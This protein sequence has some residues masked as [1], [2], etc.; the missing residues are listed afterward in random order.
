M[1]YYSITSSF[2]QGSRAGSAR[3]KNEL[4]EEARLGSFEAHEPL[5]AEPS[6]TELEPAR[7]PR[8][9]FPALYRQRQANYHAVGRLLCQFLRMA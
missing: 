6:R 2:F 5:R 4:E 8:A 1:H 3:Y 9:N 7:E